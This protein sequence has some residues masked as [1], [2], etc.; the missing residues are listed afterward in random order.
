MGKK[1]ESN[2][3]T[4]VL[5]FLLQ[6]FAPAKEEELYN[7]LQE[8]TERQLESV[9]DA[10][11]ECSRRGIFK[12]PPRDPDH[13]RPYLPNDQHLPAWALGGITLDSG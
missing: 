2:Q 5:D 8:A 1:I 13:F 4:D 3:P 7:V 9:L 10:Y 6:T 12:A 11:G